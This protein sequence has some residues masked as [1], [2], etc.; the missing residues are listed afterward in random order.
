MTQSP[1]RRALLSVSDK[2][3]I[4]ELGRRLVE[5]D[6]ELISTGGTARTL[7]DA[8]LPVTRV[9]DVTGQREILGGRVKTLHPRVHGGLLARKDLDSDMATLSQEGIGTIDLLVVNLYPFEQAITSGADFATAIENID[10]GG[11]AMIRAAAKNHESVLVA[12]DP[13][14]YDEIIA[15]IDSGMATVELRRRLALKAFART[16][17]YDSAI[18]AWLDSACGTGIPGHVRIAGDL[19]LALRYGENPHQ[20]AALYHSADRR[21]GVATATQLQGKELSYNNLQDA[22]AAFEL[23]AEFDGPGCA[24]IK[25]TNP[26]GAATAS[27][28]ADAYRQALASDPVSAFGGI[29]ALNDELDEETA[30]EVSKIFTEVVIAPAASEAARAVMAAKPNLRL[31]VTGTMPRSGESRW[32]L[33]TIAGGILAQEQ[34]TAMIATADLRCVT[35]REPTAA[36]REALLFAWKVVKHVRSNA[37]VIGQ[38]KRT[39]G[40]G[41]GQTS[42][43]DAVELAVK[44]ARATG[45]G[46]DYVL[47][48]DAFFPFADGIEAAIAAGITAVIQPG[49][50]KND[51]EVIAAADKAGVAMLF[52]GYRHFRH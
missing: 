25:H 13:A 32:S 12:V 48:S 28:L 6:V 21:P 30:R 4:V 24:I 52:T 19:A 37:I 17:A 51:A 23:V 36:E 44:K 11:P 10:I 5:R 45:V 40:V 33:K 43:V 1:V 34:D 15:A 31:L 38:G 2:S 27:T 42:R 50:S 46:G 29:I 20:R 14:D 9:A 35:R 16:S 39:L 18:A 26:C 47:A 49:G 7:G 22:D 3:G 8:G 41:C